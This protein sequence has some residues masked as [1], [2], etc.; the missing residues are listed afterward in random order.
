MQPSVLTQ[1][2]VLFAGLAS[3]C[4]AHFVLQ[5]PTSLGF[6]DEAE[7]E[8]PC[9]GFNAHSRNNVTL[10]PVEGSAVSVLTTH[11]E[12]TWEFKAALLSDLGH[13]VR[14]NRVLSQTGVGDFCEPAIPV[15]ASWAGKRGVLQVV[16]HGDDGDL[17]QCAAVKFVH[18]GPA[19]PPAG[20][21]NDTV[22]AAHW[23]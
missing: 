22:I 14:V 7:G 23:L 12:A 1:A 11:S 15:K 16:Q 3:V 10:W 9:G 19:S 8:F 21:I 5:I 2:L 13:W 4:K 6:D 18:G 20:C 17:Y